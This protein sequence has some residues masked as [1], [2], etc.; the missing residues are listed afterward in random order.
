MS[1]LFNPQGGSQ[2]GLFSGGQRRLPE[3]GPM[4]EATPAP[5]EASRNGNPFPNMVRDRERLDVLWRHLARVL[6][7]GV[8]QRAMAGESG[9]AGL[10][11]MGGPGAATGQTSAPQTQGSWERALV[12]QGLAPAQGDQDFRE[13]SQMSQG[14]IGPGEMSGQVKQLGDPGAGREGRMTAEEVA[15][16]AF[17]AGFRG[18][19]LATIVAIAMGESS[20]DPRAHNPEGRDN[21]YGLWQ[22][23]MLDRPG[24]MMGQERREKY[25][26]ENEDLWDPEV[27]ARVAYDLYQ[28][29]IARGDNPFEDWTVFTEGIYLGYWDVASRAAAM[30]ERTATGGVR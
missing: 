19:A 5:R 29:R 4:R 11:A 13:E 3:S 28:N 10:P 15:Q 1:G 9:Q 25:G 27:N 22:V 12:E 23:N 17:D 21:S 16:A 24:M 14:E 20:G 30:V 2:G 6:S 26:I 7:D 8:K 18:E